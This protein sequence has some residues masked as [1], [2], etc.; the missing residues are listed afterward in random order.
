MRLSNVVK[1]VRSW[2][3]DSRA[4]DIA[5]LNIERAVE[6]AV[7]NKLNTDDSSTVFLDPFSLFMGDQWL[8]RKH[9]NLT[10]SELRQMAQNPIIGSIVHTRLNQAAMF[11]KQSKGYDY[12]FKITKKDAEG[13]LSTSE[14][15]IGQE[16]SDFILNAGL[17]GGESSL[18]MLVRKLLRDSLIIDQ[19]CAEV[20]FRRNKLPA[21]T[22][23]VDGASIRKLKAALDPTYSEK[24]P[25]Y[26]QVID[27]KITNTYTDEQLIFGIRNPSSDIGRAGYGMS[28][29]E[30]LIT[31][32]TTLLN[33]EQYN[34]L[35][36]S[37]GGTQKGIMVIKGDVMTTEFEAFKSEFKRAVQNASRAWAPPIIRIGPTANVEWITLDRAN[38]DIEYSQ[39]FEYIVKLATGVYQI[40]PEEI[41]WT[42]GASGASVSFNS[43]AKDRLQYSVDKGLRPLLRFL[44][45]ILSR[46]LVEKINPDY[47]FEF[48]GLGTSQVDEI[49]LRIKEI[50]NYK[51]VNEIRVEAGLQGI[52]GGDIILNGNFTSQDDD[53]SENESPPFDINFDEEDDDKEDDKP[54]DKDEHSDNDKNGKQDNPSTQEKTTKGYSGHN[55]DLR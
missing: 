24:T 50:Q 40:H 23:G 31:T 13:T 39:M 26:A 8:L 11:C 47:R 9:E 34:S 12:G 4:A 35:A 10:F 25:I 18:E 17:D 19:A 49:D 42:I 21:Y 14:Q 22:V 6:K 16:I 53:S 2:I 46:Y 28:E 44:S 52:D 32:I 27:E 43:G 38:K 1:T 41:N 51:T 48:T 55:F 29:L 36:L 54:T 3:S 30:L 45:N 33:A 7:N 15:K 5:E 37:Q 20:I